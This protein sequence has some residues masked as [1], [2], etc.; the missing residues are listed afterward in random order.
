[1]KKDLKGLLRCRAY[2]L[3]SR[4]A[5]VKRLLES[6]PSEKDNTTTKG[7]AHRGI[8]EVETKGQVDQNQKKVVL[9]G[10]KLGK[11]LTEEADKD[12]V[13]K[14]LADVW[15]ELIIFMAPSS[16]EERVKGHEEVLVQGGEFITVLWA[17]T[18]QAGISRPP[19]NKSATGGHPDN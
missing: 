4:L 12:T 14:V 13:W 17:L 19:T 11:W 1:M 18:M 3:S 15:T 10:A 2:Y 9:N 8:Q 6:A 16:D 7:A 5:R